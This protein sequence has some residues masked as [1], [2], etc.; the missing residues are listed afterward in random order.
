M[1]PEAVAEQTWHVNCVDVAGRK[2]R[3]TVINKAGA[4][5]RNVILVTPPGESSRM[6]GAQLVE[7]RTALRMAAGSER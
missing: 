3:V 7:L 5:S 6:T 2:R 1:P 4:D